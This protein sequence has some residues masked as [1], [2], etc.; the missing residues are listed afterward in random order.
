M[1]TNLETR[2]RA[3]VVVRFY[4]KRGTADRRDCSDRKI[5]SQGREQA[6]WAYKIYCI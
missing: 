5:I 6:R 1:V 3:V 4:N 2:S